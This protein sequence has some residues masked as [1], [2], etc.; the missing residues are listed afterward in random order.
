VNHL[1]CW[2]SS[3]R[4]LSNREISEI[5]EATPIP[6]TANPPSVPSPSKKVLRALLNTNGLRLGDKPKNQFMGLSRAVT[7]KRIH[8]TLPPAAVQ[9][10]ARQLGSGSRPS[11]KSKIINTNPRTTS[12][13]SNHPA[14]QN[15]IFSPGS[16]SGWAES[17]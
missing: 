1:I 7:H 6:T 10:N 14:T 16:D 5:T 8:S 17:A 15:A 11:G 12:G 13:K 3:P 9:G 4:A 2:R